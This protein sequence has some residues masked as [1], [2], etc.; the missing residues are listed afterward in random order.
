MRVNNQ[1]KKSYEST[2]AGGY[3]KS[4]PSLEAVRLEKLFFKNHKGKILDFGCGPGTNGL[5][6][7]KLGYDVT[8]CDIS[9]NALKKVKKKIK[10][11]KIKKNF[12]IINFS[13]KN[14]FL[15]TKNQI[16][17]YI[18]CFSV[19][20]NLGDRK[21]AEKYINFF[22]RILKKN[23]KIIIDSN[24]RNKHNYK[25]INKKKKLY[26]THPKNNFRLKM[27]FPTK[28]D[29]KNI[30]KKNGFKIN[31]IGRAMFKIFDTKEDEVIISATKK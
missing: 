24:I 12:K 10:I 1:T 26:T 25:V 21:N 31:D 4:Y 17:D 7:L 23:G 8:F 16:F 15:K 20:N 22:H 28:N 2:Y 29:F 14:N 5:H 27:Y 9:S 3:D 30:I 19:F 18:I 6:F 11:N 13:K